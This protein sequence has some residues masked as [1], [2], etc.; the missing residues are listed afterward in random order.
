MKVKSLKDLYKVYKNSK[1]LITG[2]TGFKGS[3]L[4]LWL[5][6]YGANVSGISISVPTN[7]SLFE[8][9]NLTNEVNDHRID[10]SDLDK[11]KKIVN[12]IQPDFVF[13]LAAQPLVYESFYNPYNTW[14][15]NLNGTINIIE[16][17]LNIKKK[18]TVIFVT[19]DKVYKNYEKL[20]GY[21]EK[22]EL[23]GD[24]PYSAS[25]SSAELAINS[26]LNATLNNKDNINIGIARAGNVIGGGDWAKYRL[27]PDCVKSWSQSKIVK[28]RNPNS[29]RPWQ[30]VFEPLSGY[31]QFAA[32]LQNNMD[33]KNDIFNF[34][35]GYNNTYQVQ[36]LVKEMSKYWS[37]VKWEI[38]DKDISNLKETKLLQLDCE[39]A[40]KK[41]NWTSRWNFE[42]TIK[43]TTN[44]YKEYYEKNTVNLKK[45][46]IDQINDYLNQD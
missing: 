35:P 32:S 13:H 7:P 14:S 25:K 10:I 19:S 21:K 37:K 16:S 45:I 38:N 36:D 23:G 34:G 41:L 6:I 30:H 11:V 12:E 40:K 17:L 1:V 46:S 15:T 3:W 24:D 39:K 2:H 43:E 29:T 44:W 31:I 4:S 28:I 22:D 26:Y 27:V 8:I 20:E 18:C 33:L 5:R 42:K 9:L